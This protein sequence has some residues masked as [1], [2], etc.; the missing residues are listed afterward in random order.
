MSHKYKTFKV[1][2]FAVLLT[3]LIAAAY[4][5]WL[6]PKAVP[7][8]AA[9][10][11]DVTIITISKQQIQLYQD[12][13]ARVEAEKISDVRPQ[14]EGVIRKIYFTQGSFV[15][16]GQ[17]LYQIDSRM[18]KTAFEGAKLAW[19]AQQAKLGR[20][21]NLLEQDAISKQEYD[22]L[23][24][25]A[26]IAQADFKKAE[27]ALAYTK[28]FA[29]ISGYVGKSNFTE[30]ALVTVNQLDPLT[31]ITQ[32][33][34]LYID[35]VQPSKDAV[36]LQNQ[37]ELPVTLVTEDET[38]IEKGVLKFTE[39]FADQATD[40][41]RLRA[42]FANKEH[43]LMPGMFVT[44]KIHLTPFEAITVPQRVT[45]R[46]ADGGLTVWIVDKDNTAKQRKIKADQIAN[47]SWV[48]TEGLV[49]GDVVIFEGY[50][51]I[52][53]GAK[54]NPKA[55]EK[56]VEQ[57]P[58]K[59]VEP[60]AVVASAQVK[61]KA[62][63]SEKDK[64]SAK[65]YAA[66]NSKKNLFPTNYAEEELA[67]KSIE[68]AKKSKKILSRKRSLVEKTSIINP[69][70]TTQVTPLQSNVPLTSNSIPAN[71]SPSA[72]A[73]NSSVNAATPIAP[74]Q[75][76]PT[77]TAPLNA[78]QANGPTVPVPAVA[79]PVQGGNSGGT[80]SSITTPIQVMPIPAPASGGAK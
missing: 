21:K 11:A 34:H 18:Y 30:G 28:V 48:V 78:P 32:L 17:Q 59:T 57:N 23:S 64:I 62:K 19:K 58:A 7:A 36:K 20:Y 53:E 69:T 51:K 43:K 72:N 63:T 46:G 50:L 5:F 60:S 73:A 65:F 49:E 66:Y 70:L 27:T 1:I 55:L 80:Q 33:N 12:L 79:V 26:A 35:M 16:K 2:F 22:D 15:K 61:D 24:A 42:I 76:S 47:D 45:N 9:R 40:S 25:S 75:V 67:L 77:Q 3:G 56:P 52:A 71:N 8:P 39:T 38:L 68:K 37:R 41:V 4:F 14:A 31:T 44:A 29:P 54:V 10:V 13:P 6:K 74:G